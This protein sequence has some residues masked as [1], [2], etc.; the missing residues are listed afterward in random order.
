MEKRLFI[1]SFSEI[2]RDGRLLRQIKALAE[3]FA[4][5]VAGFGT[6]PSR[7]LPGVVFDFAPLERRR[8]AAGKALRL[9]SYLPGAVYPPAD[10]WPWSMTSEYRMARAAVRAGAFDLLLCNDLNAVL[11][12]IEEHRRRGT[13]FVADYHEFPAAEA[14]ERISSRWFKDPHGHRCLKRY[15]RLAA[16]NL[17]VNENFAAV[18]AETYGFRAVVV[19]NA[20]ELRPDIGGPRTPDGCIRLVYHGHASPNRNLELMIRALPLLPSPFVLHLMLLGEAEYLQQLQSLAAQCAPGRV[21]F[22]NPVPPPEIAARISGFDVGL[23][24]ISNESVNNRE[25]LPNKLFEYLHAGLGIC[26]SRSPA[27][28]GFI[29][30]ND[31]GWM[32]DDLT[33]EALA[34]CLLRV[35]PDDLAARK[36]AALAAREKYHA[37][38][39]TARMVQLL[40]G[41]VERSAGDDQP[42]RRTGGPALAAEPS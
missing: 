40:R 4:V 35:S 6:K 26:A 32:V 31:V 37:G 39:E 2:A 10:F 16:G 1:L 20:P 36:L 5:T 12:G 8:T 18:F 17:T 14:T 23:F 28:T 42:E 11:L 29:T 21:I 9:L 19:L 34:A 38:A 7:E 33:P 3:H 13:P 15:G 27:M 24:L 22:E 41:V 25:A 30:S